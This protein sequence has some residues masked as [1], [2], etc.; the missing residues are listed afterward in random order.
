VYLFIPTFLPSLSSFPA[1]G[2]LKIADR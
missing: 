1:A 2:K